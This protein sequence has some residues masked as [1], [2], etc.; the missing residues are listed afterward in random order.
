MGLRFQPRT[1]LTLL[2]ILLFAYV[3]YGAWEMPI[4]AKL[5][6]WTVG[7]IALVLLAYQLIREIMPSNGG[8]DRET[9]V[10]IDFTD[11]EASKAGKRK[12]LELF[13]WLYGFALLLWL[14]GFFISV[15]L[16]VLAYML[17]HKETL[18]MTLSLPVGCG[19][20]TW[21]VF[22]HFLHLPFPPGIILEA[23]GLD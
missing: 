11:E 17:R 22:G 9:G 7:I 14:L 19:A 5:Y 10:D 12:A 13:G 1:I 3:V 21:V 6:P 8:N 2:F 16:M 15:P 20:V 4:Q 23:L 18:V